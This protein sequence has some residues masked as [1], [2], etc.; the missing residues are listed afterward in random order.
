VPRAAA[1]A[2]AV[3]D[4]ARGA[5]HGVPCQGRAAGTAAGGAT[6]VTLRP[7]AWPKERLALVD[8]PAGAWRAAA[9]AGGR[10]PPPQLSRWPR[11]Q[12]QRSCSFK[13]HDSCSATFANRTG[14]HTSRTRWTRGI[15]DFIT[16]GPMTG[17]RMSF[18]IAS[19]P[20]KSKT[21][22]E[23]CRSESSGSIRVGFCGCCGLRRSGAPERAAF[24]GIELNP[25][26]WGRYRLA[27]DVASALIEYAFS[28]LDL[29]LLIGR[30][31]SA[32][33][34]VE[35]LARCSGRRSW[36]AVMGLN[37][38]RHVGGTKSIGL[39]T[40]TPGRALVAGSALV[41]PKNLNRFEARSSIRP[42]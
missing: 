41:C 3:L 30:T 5:P 34:R 21:R 32:N 13:R 2:N 26:D 6:D 29:D 8:G 19:C 36:R 35:R 18:S 42:V 7:G 4:A 25:D 16:S 1:I 31:A 27:V 20:G 40:A 24:L 23:T 12:A 22:V 38:W 10:R 14:W 15:G 37:G 9:N 33:R 17:G 39:W 11:W 28:V